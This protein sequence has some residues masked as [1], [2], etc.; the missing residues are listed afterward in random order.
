M[1]T[2]FENYKS[3]DEESPT[4]LADFLGQLTE[5]AAPALAP[6][7]QVYTVLHDILAQ[8]A[9]IALRNYIKVSCLSKKIYDTDMTKSTITFLQSEDIS[10]SRR[11]IITLGA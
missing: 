2:V 3:L 4:G 8:D 7:V 10:P 9:Q 11:S 6:A 5:V 1:A